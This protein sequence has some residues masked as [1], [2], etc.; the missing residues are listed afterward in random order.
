MA[1]PIARAAEWKSVGTEET[2]NSGIEPLICVERFDDVGTAR[3]GTQ[4]FKNRTRA[5]AVKMFDSLLDLRSGDRLDGDGGR[6][7]RR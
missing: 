2:D 7:W 5:E 1:A 6:L 4:Q 3:D